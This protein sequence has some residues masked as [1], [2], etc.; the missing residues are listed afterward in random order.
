MFPI[1]NFSTYTLRED[2]SILFHFNFRKYGWG[3]G[4]GF[5]LPISLPVLRVVMFVAEAD[6][7]SF[8][9]RTQYH[10]Y[11]GHVCAQRASCHMRRACRVLGCVAAGNVKSADSQVY[12]GRGGGTFAGRLHLMRAALPPKRLR[13]QRQP[14][15][16]QP[17]RAAQATQGQCIGE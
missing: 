9:A 2:P 6:T 10:K 3:C 7:E 11:R 4:E 16:R 14:P 8:C 17:L 13:R 12:C 1:W 15:M 5:S